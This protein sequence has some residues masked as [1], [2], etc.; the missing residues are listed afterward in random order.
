M[1]IPDNKISHTR[2]AL[3]QNDK[4]NFD[5]ICFTIFS[6]PS[7]SNQT[8]DLSLLPILN[9]E[10][11][12]LDDVRRTQESTLSKIFDA[13]FEFLHQKRICECNLKSILDLK[14]IVYCFNQGETDYHNYIDYPFKHIQKFQISLNQ[15]TSAKTFLFF[16]TETTG[17]PKNWKASYKDLNNWPRLVQIA[18]IVADI[19]GN[20]I[21]QKNHLVKPRDFTIP[22]EASKIH[23]ISTQKATE[24]GTELHIVLNEFNKYVTNTD[25]LIAHNLS[26]DINVVASELYRFK[27]DSEIFD[28][29]QI[30]TMESTTNFCKIQ[31]NYGY[32]FPKLSELYQKLF[33]TTFDEAHDASVDIKATYKCFY[34]LL[35]NKTIKI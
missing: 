14:R 34:E 5:D 32:K 7:C 31:G 13:D 8:I 2:Q 19:N 28:K 21:D 26:F 16:D 9:K 20:I 29:N 12:N 25:Y 27:I 10:Q 18:W 6:C 30:C 4:Q 1:E 11:Y 35:K 24:Q 15:K 3:Y 23:K 22:E 33:H 17:L